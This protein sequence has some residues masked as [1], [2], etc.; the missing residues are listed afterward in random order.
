LKQCRGVFILVTMSQSLA[1]ILVHAIFST[2]D[3]APFLR[4]R[5]YEIPF[6]ERHVWD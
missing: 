4:D 5:K 1:K 2:K 3:R 6:D